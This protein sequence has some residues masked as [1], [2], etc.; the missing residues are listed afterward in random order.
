MEDHFKEYE[1]NNH[2]PPH[3]RHPRSVFFPLLLVSLG[4]IL[5][6]N[7]LG[8]T[9]LSVWNLWPLIFIAGGLDSLLQ[10]NGYVGAIISIGIGSLILLSNL[11]YLESGSWMI[12]LRF[13]PILLIAWGLDLLIGRHS[14]WSKLIGAV[15]GLS[16]VAGM[17]WMTVRVPEK[18]E[19]LEPQLYSYE[20]D[21]AEEGVLSIEKITGKL[22]LS[23][24]AD[25]SNFADAYI[26][27]FE[28]EVLEDDYVV[29][30]NKADLSL[31]FD[32]FFSFPM[33][34]FGSDLSNKLDWTVK[35]NSSIPYRIY[36][37]V[38]MGEHIVNLS[39][40]KVEHFEVSTIMGKSTV[41][42]PNQPGLSGEIEVVMG[43]LTLIVPE[44]VPVY[45]ETDTALTIFDD[46]PE[47]FYRDDEVIY[48]KNADRSKD[49]LEIYIDQPIGTISIQQ[50]P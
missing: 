35:L 21:G 33:F 18:Q 26:Q 9:N 27:L 42:L 45:I 39:N 20:L 23:S 14:I 32:N 3:G 41:I 47:G 22:R 1:K 44:D 5:L 6:L 43:E 7:T 38:I 36:S 46:L 50:W 19:T 4:V 2:Q 25:P 29:H 16:L 10:G 30:N 28:N 17:L 40:V 8:I 31:K 12:I 49:R 13:W 24:G 15:I 11:H 48:S 37:E 34:S